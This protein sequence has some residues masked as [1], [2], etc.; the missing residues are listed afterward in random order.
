MVMRGAA[1]NIIEDSERAAVDDELSDHDNTQGR[2]K[3]WRVSRS[4]SVGGDAPLKVCA[5]VLHRPDS[6]T[7]LTP[8]LLPRLQVTGHNA[9][10]SAINRSFYQHRY[11]DHA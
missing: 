7:T 8:R 6:I 2:G 5:A 1:R 9:W 4:V 10:T 11:Y 3:A